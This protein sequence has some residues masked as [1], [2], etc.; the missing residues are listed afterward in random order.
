MIEKKH[1]D[2]DNETVGLIRPGLM[3]LERDSDG[4]FLG[5]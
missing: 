2:A 4:T 5:M 1:G 3:D